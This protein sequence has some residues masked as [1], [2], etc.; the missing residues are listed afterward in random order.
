[1]AVAVVEMLSQLLAL[2]LLLRLVPLLSF[3][4]LVCACARA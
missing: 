4:G 1:M 3:Q 2:K